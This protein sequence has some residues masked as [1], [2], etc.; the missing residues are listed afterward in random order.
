MSLLNVLAQPEVF[1]NTASTTYTLHSSDN[2]SFDNI[3]IQAPCTLYK[4]QA[5]YLAFLALLAWSE[6]RNR[7][8]KGRSRGQDP[9]APDNP[10]CLSFKG[11]TCRLSEEESH[12]FAT[13]EKPP[14][15][16]SDA[17]AP[18]AVDSTELK[19]YKKLYKI[20]NLEKHPEILPECR[21]LLLMFLSSTVC[22]ALQDA[23]KSTLAVKTSRKI[24]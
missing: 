11:W 24:V 18:N 22:D 20:H 10:R 3:H 19:A 8:A 23:D 4:P 7:L 12:I 15:S 17:A 6:A 16:K 9:E 13:A 1:L 21:K 5:Q 2:I 14:M